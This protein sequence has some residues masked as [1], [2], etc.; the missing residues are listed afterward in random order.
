MTFNLFKQEAREYIQNLAKKFGSFNYAAPNTI[1]NK[2]KLDRHLYD[3]I[4][5]ALATQGNN[6]IPSPIPTEAAATGSARRMTM[7][8]IFAD[9]KSRRKTISVRQRK[10]DTIDANEDGLD[11]EAEFIQNGDQSNPKRKLINSIKVNSVPS[12]K[13]QKIDEPSNSSSGD[14]NISIE[15]NHRTEPIGSATVLSVPAN[16][17]CKSSS[18]LELK[19]QSATRARKSFP[20]SIPRLFSS[21]NMTSQFSHRSMNETSFEEPITLSDYSS[22][23]NTIL[24]FSGSDGMESRQPSISKQNETNALPD[25][26]E[27]EMFECICPSLKLSLGKLTAA[28]DAVELIKLLQLEL[29][30]QRLANDLLVSK[31]IQLTKKNNDLVHDLAGVNRK[32]DLLTMKNMEVFPVNKELTNSL[33][34]LKVKIGQ[35]C[36]QI[37]GECATCR[38]PCGGD[39]CSL[40]CADLFR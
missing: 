11:K 15:I 21:S 34:N 40:Q 30:K 13:R 14:K 25:S 19:A 4:P 1:L 17:S 2:N 31:N 23:D 8:T 35:K 37:T 39:Y 3:M 24:Q 27:S 29:D 6:E 12:A 16:A 22:I 7:A 26:S 33:E 38:I 9:G 20:N 28:T 32:L 5:K 10:L 36:D 18:I